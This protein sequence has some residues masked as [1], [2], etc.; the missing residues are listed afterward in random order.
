M[1][2]LPGVDTI[3]AEVIFKK[4]VLKLPFPQVATARVIIIKTG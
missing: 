4:G 3:M 2:N 1:I